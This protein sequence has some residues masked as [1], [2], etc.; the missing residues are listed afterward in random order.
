MS[1]QK[2]EIRARRILAALAFVLSSA[3]VTAVAAQD[4][5]LFTS[6]YRGIGVYSLDATGAITVRGVVPGPLNSV[7]MDRD[8]N[9]YTCS[10]DSADV[11]KID[12][13]GNVNVYA[14]GFSGC[15]GLLFAAD[16]TLYVSNVFAGRIEVVAPGGGSIATLAGGLDGPMHMA[17]DLDGSILVTQFF[18]GLVSR[19]TLSGAVSTVASGLDNPVGVAVGPDGNIYVSELFTGRITRTD[20][21]GTTSL[22]AATDDAGPTGLDFHR[23]GRLFVAETFAGRVVVADIGTGAVT[24]FRDGLV[25]PAGLDFSRQRELVATVSVDL[26]P[27]DGENSV[28]PKSRGKVPVA[29]LGSA[30]FDV[31]RIDPVTV[32]FG[33]TGTEAAATQTSV[34]D[35][36]GDGRLDMVFHFPT[37]MLGIPPTMPGGSLLPLKLTGQ[38]LDGQ[39]IAGEDVA[40]ITPN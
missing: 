37:Q 5:P 34:A 4:F 20:H 17:F 30:A 11:S 31:T 23:D 26:K 22:F 19:V 38:T 33:V 25:A 2:L 3:I 28:N 35:V 21:G 27:G 6:D 24:V 13:A 9:L 39:A 1:S 29:I 14:T 36:N 12:P 32:R 8:A 7:R 10:E 18:S 40:Q 15:F 16:G